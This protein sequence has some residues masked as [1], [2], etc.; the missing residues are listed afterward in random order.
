[1]LLV[2]DD[3]DLVETVVQYLELE[4][5]E[6]DHATNGRNGLA[7]ALEN[8]YRVLLLDIM[9]PRMDGLE[10]CQAIRKAGIDTPVLMLTAR[11]TLADK[12]AGFD[13]GT[14]DYMVKP[15]DMEELVARI[16]A[17]AGRRSGHVKKLQVGDLVMDLDRR[18][19]TRAGHLL[20]L[21]PSG[22][23]LLEFLMRSHPGTVHRRELEQA[24]WQD[25]PPNSNSL[26]V[27]MHHL[28]RQ[29]DKSFDSPMIETIPGHGFT[30]NANEPEND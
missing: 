29:V 4:E 24:L 8:V 12:L 13:A 9:L 15:F 10:V 30:I 28:R 11:D 1:M 20:N 7:L 17:L 25:D 3:F 22:W 14:D 2:E 5:I 21:R 27:H 26:K 23:T 19:V 18:T 6:C 16:R